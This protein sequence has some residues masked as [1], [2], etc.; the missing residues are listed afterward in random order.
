[1]PDDED[2]IDFLLTRYSQ[3]NQKHSHHSEVIHRTFYLSLIFLGVII[4]AIIQS[5]D[6]LVQVSLCG[7]TALIFFALMLWTR[8][9]TNGR[10]DFNRQKNEIIAELQQ[11]EYGFSKIDQVNTLFPDDDNRDWWETSKPKNYV[12]LS[13]YT[14]VILISI[15]FVLLFGTGTL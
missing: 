7:L 5:T 10:K 13:Y 2:N 1:M 11:C 8:T 14:S 6:V 12:L 4:N 3:I 9:Y 15:V